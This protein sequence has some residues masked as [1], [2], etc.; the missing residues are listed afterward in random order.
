[1]IL[2]S[3]IVALAAL[4]GGYAWG[5]RAGRAEGAASGRAAAPLELRARALESDR[6]P[7]C[8]AP[9]PVLPATSP[10]D[11]VAPRPAAD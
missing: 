1:M 5:R 7:V 10:E 4:L 3:S 2:E 11:G 6:C 9:H 8:G